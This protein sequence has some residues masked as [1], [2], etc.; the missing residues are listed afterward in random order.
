M[1][2]QGG[3]G[4]R[5]ATYLKGRLHLL[6]TEIDEAVE[7]FEA[8]F[9]LMPDW[10]P[11]VLG[12]GESLLSRACEEYACG[13]LRKSTETLDRSVEVLHGC[14]KKHPQLLAAWKMLGDALHRQP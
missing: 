10:A 6:L 1:P 11:A 3:E 8:L 7:E 4:N 9:A 13:W 12:L 14:V 5:S 2:G